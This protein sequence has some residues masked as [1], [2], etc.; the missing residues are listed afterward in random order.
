M[1][2]RRPFV[3]AVA[4]LATAAVLLA[5]CTSKPAS[6]SRDGDHRA[7]PTTGIDTERIG[8]PV[9]VKAGDRK[10]ASA[11]A[12]QV[13]KG[14]PDGIAALATAVNLAGI[15]LT[16]ADGRVF[17]KPTNPSIGQTLQAGE[18]G[19][20]ASLQARGDS[21]LVLGPML[22]TVIGGLNPDA[23]LDEKAIM[24]GLLVDLRTAALGKNATDAFIAT[25]VIELEKRSSTPRDLTGKVAD[26]AVLRVSPVTATLLL[27]RMAAGIQA[28][29]PKD[30]VKAA[31]RGG[32]TNKPAGYASGAGAYRLAGKVELDCNLTSS[33]GVDDFAYDRL[34]D[35]GSAAGWTAAALTAAKA[36]LT[37]FGAEMLSLV[38]STVLAFVKLVVA[39]AFFKPTME[40]APNK[41][42]RT[43]S[44]SQDG[45]KAVVTVTLKFDTEGW[46]VANCFRPILAALGLDISF[47]SGGLVKDAEVTWQPKDG[48][49]AA[50]NGMA[51]VKL[52]DAT[53]VGVSSVKTNDK[54]Q[55]AVTVIGHRQPTEVPDT[56]KK[57]EKTFRL[58]G[59]YN[60]KPPDEWGD[61]FEAMGIAIT[62]LAGGPAGWITAFMKLASNALESGGWYS[63]GASFPV[64]DYGGDYRIETTIGGVT[65]SGTV[66]NGPAGNWKVKMSGKIESAGVGWTYTGGFTAAIKPNGTGPVSGVLNGKSTS[67]MGFGALTSSAPFGGTAKLHDAGQTVW[68]EIK[69]AESGAKI[70][71]PGGLISS[72]SGSGTFTLPVDVGNFCGS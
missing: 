18:V 56:A 69:L 71:G 20:L 24:N 66:C 38:V 57:V 60:G 53:P 72:G 15:T 11:L 2:R 63:F 32:A 37:A 52:D 12:E 3:R 67:I 54:G 50:S 45:A 61:M 26:P 58:E 28:V 43:R 51:L 49:T 27:L 23:K 4:L 9:Q 8:V 62:A 13:M 46:E 25:F 30:M 55:A 36:G 68:L 7:F 34:G 47:K 39:G 65:F 19:L 6:R 64:L 21:L 31:Q 29:F 48:F 17:R 59:Y 33:E 40:M 70:A 5:G 16:G 10:A 44:A 35:L 14:G 41:L 42:E 1:T 22:T